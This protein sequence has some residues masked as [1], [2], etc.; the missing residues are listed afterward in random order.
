MDIDQFDSI[1]EAFLSAMLVVLVLDWLV[2]GCLLFGDPMLDILN[3][4]I[5][6]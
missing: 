4:F 3:V 5:R 2:C 1:G 6:M